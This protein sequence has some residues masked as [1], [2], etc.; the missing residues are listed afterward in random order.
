MEDLLICSSGYTH[1]SPVTSEQLQVVAK[2]SMVFFQEK[3]E[4]S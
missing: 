1:S 4:S 3:F 2:L